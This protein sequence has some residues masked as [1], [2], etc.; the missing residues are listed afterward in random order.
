[1]LG[2]L[3]RLIGDILSRH[4]SSVIVELTQ[5]EASACVDTKLKA[6]KNYGLLEGIDRFRILRA[7][8][9]DKI[10]AARERVK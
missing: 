4:S 3:A 2:Y 9:K 5:E 7:S 8:A 6:E 10:R 1:M